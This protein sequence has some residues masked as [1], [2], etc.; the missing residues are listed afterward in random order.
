MED[1]LSQQPFAGRAADLIDN[2]VAA[3][4]EL[5][6]TEHW[7]QA[8]EDFVLARIKSL[9]L[10]GGLPWHK[11]PLER[12]E[13]IQRLESLLQLWAKGCTCAM[14]EVL[15]ADILNRHQ[16]GK[17]TFSRPSFATYSASS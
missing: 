2:H 6:G 8:A 17:P 11:A 7:Q 5:S 10:I 15:F 16:G 3:H 13:R 9:R 4:A 12:E 1:F 14:D